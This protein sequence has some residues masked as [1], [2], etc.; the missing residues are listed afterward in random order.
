MPERSRDADHKAEKDMDAN[1]GDSASFTAVPNLVYWVLIAVGVAVFIA[2]GIA[3]TRCALRPRLANNNG[4]EAHATKHLAQ[5]A[6]SAPPKTQVF[7]NHV[8]PASLQNLKSEG[9]KDQT[10][11][12]EFGEGNDERV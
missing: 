1:E 9:G 4:S 10:V 5:L 6:A 2:I 11:G 3:I 8:Q 7:C 12:Q